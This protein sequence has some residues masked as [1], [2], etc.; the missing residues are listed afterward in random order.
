MPRGGRGEVLV[1]GDHHR[2][3]GAP[4]RGRPYCKRS[5][6]AR[7]ATGAAP[8]SGA[9]LC[10]PQPVDIHVARGSVACTRFPSQPAA[11][12]LPSR[13]HLAIRLP[14]SLHL[15][16]VGQIRAG[17]VSPSW[18]MKHEPYYWPPEA[19]NNRTS[20]KLW[21][22]TRVGEYSGAP[23]HLCCHTLLPV[24]PEAFGASGACPSLCWRGNCRLD[25]EVC[26]ATGQPEFSASGNR[27]DSPSQTRALRFAANTRRD[28][29]QPLRS[30]TE[31]QSQRQGTRSLR[32]QKLRCCVSPCPHPA[33]CPVLIFHRE[34]S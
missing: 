19:P 21:P 15:P 26:M 11:G 12:I 29:T 6:F 5:R 24:G 16:S 22:R 9:S 20:S 10:Q 1:R 18:K 32:S 4:D 23:A 30:P 27:S 25:S 7:A 8:P 14:P 17:L 2:L 33:I 34:A 28:R 3:W 13:L 31:Q